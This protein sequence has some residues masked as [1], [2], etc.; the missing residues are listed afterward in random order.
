MVSVIN[1]KKNCMTQTFTLNDLILGLYNEIDQN[2]LERSIQEELLMLKEI[3]AL[4]ESKNNLP[5]VLF[6]PQKAIIEKILQAAKHP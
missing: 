6:R 2:I 1:R 4:K 5:K 3:K